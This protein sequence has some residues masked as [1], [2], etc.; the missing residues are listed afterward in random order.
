MEEI[1]SIITQK[2]KALVRSADPPLILSKRKAI[3]ALL[4]FA[5]SLERDGPQEIFDTIFRVARASIPP[6]FVWGHAEP[7]LPTLINELSPPSLDRAIALAAPYLRWDRELNVE[8]AVTRWA[9]AASVV[10]YTEEIALS[11]VDALL[12]IAGID[13]LRPLIPSHL[14]IWLKKRPSLPPVCQ[15]RFRGAT[16]NVVRHI[17]EL[18]DIEITKSYFLLVWSAWDF[19]HLPDLD[20]VKISIREDFGG[21]GM[22]GHRRDL[23]QRLDQAV[24]ELGRGMEYFKRHKPWVNE[25]S[26]PRRNEQLGELKEVLLEADREARETLTGIF[27]CLILCSERANLCERLQNLARPLLVLYLFRVRDLS[28]GPE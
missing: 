11:V 8:K 22:E 21:I 15:G 10:P 3:S 18:G 24:E 19:H 14:W 5:M 13:S 17:R 28:S 9:A 16:S 12:Q 23:L 26:I 6:R 25:S 1:S 27:P 2:L 7:S 4:P 20:E